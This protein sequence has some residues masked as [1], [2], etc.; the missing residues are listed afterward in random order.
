MIVLKL[1]SPEI[2]KICL[3]I[4]YLSR[5]VRLANPRA[6]LLFSRK[7]GSILTKNVY[8]IKWRFRTS[9]KTR[10]K[11]QIHDKVIETGKG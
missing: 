10:L 7:N 6:G 4:C 5:T 9:V 8:L 11:L 3:I 1:M 2:L